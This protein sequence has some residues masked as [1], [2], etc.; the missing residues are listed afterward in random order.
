MG[1]WTDRRRSHICTEAKQVGAHVVCRVHPKRVW[2]C[3]PSCLPSTHVLCLLPFSCPSSWHPYPPPS[4]LQTISENTLL[5]HASAALRPAPEALAPLTQ[6]GLLLAT[7]GLEDLG[8]PRCQARIQTA[9]PVADANPLHPLWQTMPSHV[10]TRGSLDSPQQC[11]DHRQ[12]PVRR[13]CR[14]GE[15]R[16]GRGGRSA[17]RGRLL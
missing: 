11:A 16:R 9:M 14:R 15:R 1:R 6:P 12:H 5:A 8:R 2:V 17:G 3:L 4:S 10:D 7:W 13:A